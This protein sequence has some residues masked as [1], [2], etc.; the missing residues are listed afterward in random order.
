MERHYD[1]NF[2]NKLY[3]FTNK[4]YTNYYGLNSPTS[5]KLTLMKSNSNNNSVQGEK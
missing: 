2:W 4:Y 3:I 1:K 5:E